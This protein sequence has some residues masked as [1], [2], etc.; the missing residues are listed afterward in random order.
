MRVAK[1]S[2]AVLIK[3]KQNWIIPIIGLMALGLL[4]ALMARR[5]EPVQ[6]WT[7]PQDRI[8]LRLIADADH[9]AVYQDFTYTISGWQGAN[10]P[11]ENGRL[12]PVSAGRAIRLPLSLDQ[13]HDAA[14]LEADVILTG[15]WQQDDLILRMGSARLMLGQEADGAI[16]IAPARDSQNTI[17]GFA[18]AQPQGPERRISI[19]AILPDYP[20][21]FDLVFEA[22]LGNAPD[23]GFFLDNLRLILTDQPPQ[24]MA[25]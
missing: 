8:G 22:P 19:W 13:S 21:Q 14:V 12:G 5:G 2:K 7:T 15:N 10:G 16:T 20:A 9:L 6:T 25:N 18:M 3:D 4:L 23:R 11:D 24:F 17:R 1:R